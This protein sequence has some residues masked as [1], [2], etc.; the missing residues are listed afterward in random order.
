MLGEKIAQLRKAKGISQEELGDIL[1]TSR[2][3]IS[4]WERGEANPDISRLKDLAVYFNVSIDYLLGYDVE[5][6]SVNNFIDRM[7]RSCDTANYDISIE[8]IKMIVSRNS[9]NLNLILEA[10][11]YLGD[12]YYYSHQEGIL[13]LLIQYIKKSITI[14]QPNNSLKADLNSLHYAIA[15]IYSLKGEYELAKQYLEENQVIKAEELLSQCEL[16]LGHYAE[17]EKIVSEIFLNSCGTLINTNA[18]QIR[19]FLRTN[20]VKDALDLAE[21]SIGFAKSITKDEETFLN[22]VYS[23]TFMKAC[24]EKALALDYSNSLKYLKENHNK[25]T[26]F[27]SVSDGL[28]FYNNK[29]IILGSE[30]GDIKS[31]LLKE[32]NQLKKDKVAGY[33][34]ALDIF[35]EIYGE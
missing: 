17:V 10:V 24:C 14:F 28:K 16:S 6:N 18:I 30:T 29:H 4:K 31:D 21:W 35:K 25:T 11:N 9:N 23:F 34:N 19:A 3:A 27:K 32:I 15:S 13:D 8:D 5:S 33:Q 22:I 7:K 12:Y 2:Q 1:S 20:R 26:G